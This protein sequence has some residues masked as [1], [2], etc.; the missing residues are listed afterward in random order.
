MTATT[1]LSN[2]CQI[3]DRVPRVTGTQQAVEKAGRSDELATQVYLKTLELRRDMELVLL[4]NQAEVTGDAT[5]ARTLGAVPSWIT[6]N[7]SNGV[8]GSD[9]S[10][11]NTAR[12]D[13]TQ[14][15]FTEA[16]L[17]GVLQDTW[18]SGGDPDCIMVGAFNKRRMSTFAGNATRY[19]DAEKRL[20]ETAIDVYASDWG[21]LEII[22]N[23]FMRS[24]DCLILQKDL[25]A[26]GYLRPVHVTEL[27]KTGDSDR[28]QILVEYTLVSRNEAGSGAVWDLTTS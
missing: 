28:R 20:L 1:R 24:R 19:M 7:T 9:G 22:P 6:T 26:V 10:L 16:L 3:S 17:Q 18:T 21:V 8:G 13:G 2:T 12:T 23:R 14:R 4:R 27:A 11:G 25:W 15:D 5:T